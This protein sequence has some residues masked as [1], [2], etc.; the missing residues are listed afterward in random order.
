MLPEQ[1]DAHHWFNKL[2][3]CSLDLELDGI[4]KQKLWFSGTLVKGWSNGR[5]YSPSSP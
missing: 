1:A 4:L 2:C 3:S 5:V